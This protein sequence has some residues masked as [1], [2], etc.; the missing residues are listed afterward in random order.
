MG[1]HLPASRAQVLGWLMLL[2]LQQ[3]QEV[4][5]RAMV[6]SVSKRMVVANGGKEAPF[7]VVMVPPIIRLFEMSCWM[8]KI[9]KNQQSLYSHCL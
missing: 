2:P 9:S 6:Y 4:R 3:A 5:D 8:R 1:P 7:T